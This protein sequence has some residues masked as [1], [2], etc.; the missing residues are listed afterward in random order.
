MAWIFF[1]ADSISQAYHILLRVFALPVGELFVPELDKFV[2]GIIAILI[3]L[4][5]DFVN[6]TKRI[7]PDVIFQPRAIRWGSYIAII[8]I[9][10]LIGVFDE[11]QF[12]Y[13]QF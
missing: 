2:Y 11:S 4:F 5:V 7:A 13:F 10:I 1:R 8:V 6:E 9:M 3:L 12:I